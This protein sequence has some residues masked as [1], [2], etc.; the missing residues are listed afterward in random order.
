MKGFI[1]YFTGMFSGIWSLLTGM[2]V[3]GKNFFLAPWRIVTQRYPENR[4]K[5]KMFDSYKGELLMPHNE[6][7]E[8]KCTACG[9]CEMNCPNGSIEVISIMNINEEGKKKRALDK[10]VYHLGMCTFCALCVNTCPSKALAWGQ[11]FEQATFSRAALNKILNNEGSTL[12][13]GVE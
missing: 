6:N 11:N 8:H 4:K 9:I 3:T 7:N 1:N 2:K 12:M 5:L 13:K 10:Y